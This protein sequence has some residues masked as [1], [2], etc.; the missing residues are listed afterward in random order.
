MPYPRK[1]PLPP[2]DSNLDGI[3]S[4]IVKFRKLRGMTQKE[5]AER[6]GITREALASHELGRVHLSDDLII[7]FALALRVSSDE[8]LGLKGN[9]LVTGT[10]PSVRV[11]KRMQRIQ[12]L[13]PVNQKAILRTIDAF[14]A[15]VETTDITKLSRE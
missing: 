9:E 4:R 2:L 3:A 13:S 10:I 14:L 6:I 7:R 8:L 12:E 11:I 15:G 1:A 5:L